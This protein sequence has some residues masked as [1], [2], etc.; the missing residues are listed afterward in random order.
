V[1]WP[2]RARHASYGGRH[3]SYDGGRRTL[4]LSAAAGL[5]LC[6]PEVYIVQARLFH[7]RRSLKMDP[8][9]A[10]AT[11]LKART[12]WGL[13]LKC[14]ELRTRQHNVND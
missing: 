11:R 6:Q 13:V 1:L 14:Y 3:A 8:V 12:C 5:P 7:H 4:A 9:N 10:I 2:S